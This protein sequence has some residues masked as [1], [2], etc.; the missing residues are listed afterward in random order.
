MLNFT[1]SAVIFVEEHVVPDGH[2][3]GEAVGADGV[4]SDQE[5]LGIAIPVE[6]EEAVVDVEQEHQVVTAG[7]GA[8]VHVPAGNV[9]GDD[10]GKGGRLRPLPGGGREHGHEGKK[11][12]EDRDGA[13]GHAHASSGDLRL[14]A[15]SG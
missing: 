9:G 10:H 12:S 4:L 8:G 3:D 11:G 13:P 6:F 14:T 1:S 15:A 2:G 5:G 7:G